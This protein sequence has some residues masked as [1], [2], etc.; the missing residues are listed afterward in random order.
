MNLA[1]R[2]LMARLAATPGVP[3]AREELNEALARGVPDAD[4]HRLEML[5]YRLRRKCLKQARAELPLRA[6]R[7]VG[8]VLTW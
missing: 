3:V 2:T 4:P 5:V 6:V 7:G 8:Y 1:E